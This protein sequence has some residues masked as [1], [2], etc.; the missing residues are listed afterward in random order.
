MKLRSQNIYLEASLSDFAKSMNDLNKQIILFESKAYHEK[1][2]SSYLMLESFFKIEILNNHFSFILYDKIGE[3]LILDFIKEA[4]LT[5]LKSSDSEIIIS[6][7]A[8]HLFASQDDMIRQHPYFDIIR[9]LIRFLKKKLDLDNEFIFPMIFAYDLIDQFYKLE[10]FENKDVPDFQFFMPKEIYIEDQLKHKIQHFSFFDSDYSNSINIQDSATSIDES[11]AITK[12][13]SDKAYATF[14]AKSKEHIANGDVYQL[15]VSRSFK[16]ACHQPFLAYEELREMNPSPYMFFVNDFGN[17]LF[18]ASPERAVQ[19]DAKSK[20][21]LTSPIAGTKARVFEKDGSINLDNDNK[22]ALELKLDQK[23]IAEHIMLVDLARNDISSISEAG[24][25]TV[26]RLMEI[27]S[28]SHVLHLVSEVKGQLKKGLDAFHAYQALM[29]MGTLT[30]S[31]KFRAYQL[32]RDIEKK[33]R[34]YYGGSIGFIKV[35]GSFNSAIIIR[36]AAVKNNIATISAGAGVV[37]D[38]QIEMEVQESENKAKAVF[39]SILKS[40][41]RKEQI[42]EKLELI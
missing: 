28:Y 22:L 40:Q 17:Y 11:E 25:R 39:L 34:A 32:L 18:G 12:T 15:V 27:E 41:K 26:S 14:I 1:N 20:E 3:S 31:P 36:S 24:T 16:L 21:V 30:G 42:H 8:R 19:Y 23:E 5:I 29:N 10:T 37:H 38:S 33:A 35:D 6:F 13:I 2:Y 4:Q 9:S 7:T